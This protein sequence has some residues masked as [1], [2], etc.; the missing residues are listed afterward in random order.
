ME[1]RRL[2]SVAR[3]LRPASRVVLYR[4][5]LHVVARA[6][7]AASLA[8]AARLFVVSSLVEQG[9]AEVF[10]EGGEAADVAP[11]QR[12]DFRGLPEPLPVCLGQRRKPA[13]TR[14]AAVD[15]TPLSLEVRGRVQHVVRSLTPGPAPPRSRT[16]IRS[17]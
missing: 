17:P 3:K 15:A 10:E 11:V 12:G 6:A 8:P 7:G 2:P 9:A 5:L 1:V 16:G 4:S 13:C 14:R